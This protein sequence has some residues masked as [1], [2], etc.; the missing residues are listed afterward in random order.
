MPELTFVA[1]VNDEDVFAENLRASPDLHEHQVIAVRDAPS[2]ADGLNVG[3]EQARGAHVVLVHQDV[4]L[5]EGW[6]SEFLAQLALAEERFGPVGVAGV[7]GACYAPEHPREPNLAG[8]V[9]DRGVERREI[10]ALPAA[11]ETLDELL[12]VV[13]RSMPWRL[14][15]KLGWHLYGADL[16][17]QAR[18]DGA[19]A[20]VLD[21]PCFHNSRTD[22]NAGAPSG[23]EAS[24][25]YFRQKWRRALPIV[26][27]CAVMEPL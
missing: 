10:H 5:P 7:F 15:P 19:V 23:F 2:A 11:V 27:T 20:V 4:Y 22:I 25:D 9:F 8:H 3:I 21:A 6:V 24:V 1:C 17:C 12:L 13:P 14:D 26:T 16:A 18:N